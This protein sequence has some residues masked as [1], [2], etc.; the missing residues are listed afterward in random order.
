MSH[1]ETTLAAAA[2]GITAALGWVTYGRLSKVDA[3]DP[4]ERRGGEY[5]L[6]RTAT[7]AIASQSVF[8]AQW[9]DERTLSCNVI[10]EKS[11]V[12]RYAFHYGF[13]EMEIMFKS[14]RP[15][16]FTVGG[17]E[18]TIDSKLEEQLT[19]HEVIFVA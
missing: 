9:L 12:V 13:I 10:K 7:L 1:L 17:R 3:Y 14:G 2:V 11:H 6:P 16:T 19:R 4:K 8:L 5:P 15:R 18:Y